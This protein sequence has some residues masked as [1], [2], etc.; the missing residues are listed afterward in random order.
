MNLLL[1]LPEEISAENIALIRGVRA[2]ELIQLHDLRKDLSIRAGV[3]GGKSGKATIKKI[4]SEQLELEVDL[5]QPEL[6]R[7]NCTLLVGACRPQTSK[8]IIEFAA[9]A[10]VN[11]LH[12]VRSSQSDKNYL[13]SKVLQ[14]EQRLKHLIKG[15]EQAADTIMPEVQVHLSFKSFMLKLCSN[16]LG[17]KNNNSNLFVGDTRAGAWSL[18]GISSHLRSPDQHTVLAIGPESGF[19]DFE[20]DSLKQAGFQSL[21][22]GNR[23]FRIEQA[24]MM[25]FAQTRPELL[26]AISQLPAV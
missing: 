5:Y 15:L 21:S 4:E 24:L 18:D 7:S 14:P 1:I 22:L 6:P 13:T 16:D 9:C 8:R 17:F 2:R 3:L 11:S 19:S 10:G 26:R 20:M 12:F 25:L 23:Q